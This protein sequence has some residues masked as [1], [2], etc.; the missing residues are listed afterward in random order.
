M[1]D[2][3]TLY[4][5]TLSLSKKICAIKKLPPVPSGARRGATKLVAAGAKRPLP[6]ASGGQRCGRDNDARQRKSAAEAKP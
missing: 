6:T 1:F 4:K 3:L 2:L 5:K